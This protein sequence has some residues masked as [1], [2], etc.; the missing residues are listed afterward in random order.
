MTP[1]DDVFGLY[2][3]QCLD[4]DLM[5]RIYNSG[6]SAPPPPRLHPAAAPPISPS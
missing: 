5:L 4:F 3:D 2:P 1:M 6:Y